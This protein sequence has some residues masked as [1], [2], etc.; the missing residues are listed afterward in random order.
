MLGPEQIN[1]PGHL[2]TLAAS[3]ASHL[4]VNHEVGRSLGL[5]NHQI[6]KGLI[7][8]QG[9][10]IGLRFQ[11]QFIELPKQWQGRIGQTATFQAVAT[12][13]GF[14]LIPQAAASALPAL[15]N[16]VLR[17]WYKPNTAPQILPNLL[18]SPTLT[19]ALTSAGLQSMISSLMLSSRGI[20]AQTLSAALV[21]SGLFSEARIKRGQVSYDL[22]TALRLLMQDLSE[23]TERS[24]I[25]GAID[26]IEHRQ[27]ESLQAQ[28]RLDSLW[29]FSIMVDEHPV[30]IMLQKEASQNATNSTAP[31][32]V[33]DI[34]TELGPWG[35]V[36][37][38][39]KLYS[40]ATIELIAWIPNHEIAATAQAQLYELELALA[41]FDIVLSRCQVII[42]P[43]PSS[44]PGVTARGQVVDLST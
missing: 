7:E 18:Q 12:S 11:G 4:R 15:S 36:W 24:S 43:R 44:Q 23:T 38:N 13:Q 22:K 32:W 30:D 34:S 5:M 9:Q 33:V 35:Q 8:T 14:N 37:L 10:T 28:Q 39:S 2:T 3:D 1:A 17:L 40:D 27:L 26:E 21:N 6:I 25:Q 42:E 20:T 29:H 19:A 31:P 16:E 41:E